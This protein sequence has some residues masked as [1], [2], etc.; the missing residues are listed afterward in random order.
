MNKME[1]CL[2][3][4][5]SIESP[6]KFI[7]VSDNVAIKQIY[8]FLTLEKETWL[9]MYLNWQCYKVL[10]NVILLNNCSCQTSP[11]TKRPSSFLLLLLSFGQLKLEICLLTFSV[12]ME[13]LFSQIRLF[14]LQFSMSRATNL[15]VRQLAWFL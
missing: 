14:Q 7:P 13:I 8:L 15:T 10:S 6:G 11:A 3:L 4:H 2:V 5:N 1:Q 9:M 12:K